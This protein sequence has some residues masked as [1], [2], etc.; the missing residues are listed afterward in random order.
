MVFSGGQRG[1]KVRE[2]KKDKKDKK[3][4]KEGKGDDMWESVKGRGVSEGRKEGNAAGGLKFDVATLACLNR[5]ATAPGGR[6]GTPPHNS[7]RSCSG[8]GGR[9]LAF[10]TAPDLPG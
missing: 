7:F 1:K 2:H 4:K 8:L 3:D 10:R 9:R 5:D 6:R